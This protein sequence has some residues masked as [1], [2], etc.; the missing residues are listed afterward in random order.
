MTLEQFYKNYDSLVDD[1]IRIAKKFFD[2]EHDDLKE[3]IQTFLGIRQRLGTE[4]LTDK[5]YDIICELAN[6][7]LLYVYQSLEELRNLK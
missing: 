6:R 3:F 1:E 2:Y 7:N 5:D 4:S